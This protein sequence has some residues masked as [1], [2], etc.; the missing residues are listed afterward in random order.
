VK[1]KNW[2]FIIPGNMIFLFTSAHAMGQN[3]ITHDSTQSDTLVYTRSMR[4]E[5]QSGK[6]GYCPEC[7]MEL[8]LKNKMQKGTRAQ[9][10]NGH[11]VPEGAWAE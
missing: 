6:P 9:A 11:D 10:Q 7:G 3:K 8:A 2:I 5:I 4:P 1:P